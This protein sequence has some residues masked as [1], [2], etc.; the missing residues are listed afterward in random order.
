MTDNDWI[1][2]WCCTWRW[3]HPGWQ[4]WLLAEQGVELAA[5]AAVARSRHGDLLNCL[6]IT[7]T[8]P[9][10]PSFDVLNWLSLNAE[11][12][13]LALTLVQAVCS[14]AEMRTLDDEC[15]R[16]CRSLAKALRPGLWLAGETVDARAMLGGW[17]GESCWSR[18]RLAWAPDD[19]LTAAPDLPPRKLDALW[20]AVLWK[21]KGMDKGAA[22]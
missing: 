17:L 6:G 9:P 18:L 13:V 2:W 21:V 3:M 15:W 12:R 11:Q 1:D 16:W 4:P 7:P 22:C 14:S 5:F 20:Q 8:Q 19:D 10:E